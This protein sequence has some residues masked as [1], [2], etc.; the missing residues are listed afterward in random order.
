MTPEQKKKA[1]CERSKRWRSRL[2][3][4]NSPPQM[5]G[6]MRCY[7]C[8][9]EKDVTLFALDKGRLNG[10]RNECKNCM[11]QLNREQYFKHNWGITLSEFDAMKQKQDGCCGCCGKKSEKLVLDHDHKSGLLRQLICSACNSG[12]GYFSDDPEKL[13]LT[14]AYLERHQREH[15]NPL[16]PKIKCLRP[17]RTSHSGSQRQNL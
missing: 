9:T 11:K 7:V 2:K 14:I 16:V 10:R 6:S 13:K 5:T 4:K 8:E 15:L 17:W 1:A 3:A 12:I